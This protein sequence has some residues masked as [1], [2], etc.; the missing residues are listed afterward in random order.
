MN[1]AG[2]KYQQSSVSRFYIGC[3]RC[4]NWFHGSCVGITKP[5]AEKLSTYLCPNCRQP[6]NR[7]A[8]DNLVLTNSHWVEIEKVMSNLKVALHM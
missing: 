6:N 4:Q 2:V 1:F 7:S 8:K 5:E 3:D